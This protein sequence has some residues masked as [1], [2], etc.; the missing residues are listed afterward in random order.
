MARRVQRSRP[1][2]LLLVL[3]LSALAVGAA[4][5]LLDAARTAGPPP[6]VGPTTE[7]IL[8]S[9][10]V[11]A[12]IIAFAIGVFLPVVY[13]RIRSGGGGSLARPFLMG[14]MALLLAG[15]IAVALLHV[16]GGGGTGFQ[17]VNG[18][19]GPNNSTKPP[20]TNT[21]CNCTPVPGPGGVLAPFNLHLPPWTLFFLV[22]VVAVAAV[23][24]ALP[25]LAEYL[26][27]RKESR[28]FRARS[29]QVA[30]HVQ[31]ALQLA[32]RELENARDPRA[33]I[34]ALYATLL[35]RIEPLTTNLDPATPEEIRTLH[36]VRLGIRDSAAEDLTRVFE[37]ARYSSHPLGPEQ[38]A[39]AAN[40]I[41]AAEEDL[42]RRGST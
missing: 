28:L 23:V 12:A 31:R 19:S 13:A 27:D 18:G 35:S 42:A 2:I 6:P 33:T 7:I 34:L 4:V 39:R 5:S 20:P 26:Q 15:V 1:S 9:W 41:R 40:S 8:P 30:D 36:L 22:A 3:L 10:V 21:T 17:T 29:A 25:P 11:S 32:A 14:A 38:V 16:L 37:E 24:L